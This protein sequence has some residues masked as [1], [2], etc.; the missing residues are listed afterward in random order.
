MNT[1]H[2]SVTATER[3]GTRGRTF[4]VHTT[5]DVPDAPITHDDRTGSDIRPDSLELEYRRTG[6]E[7]WQCTRLAAHGRVVA[8]TEWPRTVGSRGAVALSP[9][10]IDKSPDRHWMGRLSQ[11]FQSTLTQWAGRGLRT[12]DVVRLTNSDAEKEGV[13]TRGKV[14]ALTDINGASPSDSMVLV[15]WGPRG[16]PRRWEW[17][18]TLAVVE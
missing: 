2:Q 13:D 11:D 7:P 8:N 16:H 12:D 14:V 15:A 1:P 17:I 5:L 18:E 9:T 6:C 10:Q 4:A 3:P